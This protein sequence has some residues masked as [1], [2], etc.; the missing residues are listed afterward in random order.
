MPKLQRDDAPAALSVPAGAQV[1][2]DRES[3]LQREESAVERRVWVGTRI[4]AVIRY[5]VRTTF[6]AHL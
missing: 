1:W 2:P 3:K 4:R 6:A 5:M